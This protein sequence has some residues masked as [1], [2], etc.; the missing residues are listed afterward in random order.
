MPAEEEKRKLY[1]KAQAKA[2]KTQA[3]AANAA[4]A[5][6]AANGAA[7][8]GR[9]NSTLSATGS[10]NSGIINPY[11]YTSS[12]GLKGADLYKSATSVKAAAT[13]A[14][15][16]PSS[17][18]P[19]IKQTSPAAKSVS[20]PSPAT[21][22]TS[23]PPTSAIPSTT[24]S[25]PAITPPKQSNSNWLSAEDEKARLRYLD[26]KRAVDKHI[27]A[28]EA[29]YGA[30]TSGSSQYAAILPQSA[31]TPPPPTDSQSWSMAP[32][33][34][35]PSNLPPLITPT[36]TPPASDPPPFEP[37]FG[38]THATDIPEKEKMRLAL[39]H[40]DSVRASQSPPDYTTPPAG[41]LPNED[42]PNY[43]SIMSPDV[44]LSATEEKARLRAQFAAQDALQAASSSSAS[45][46]G[47]GSGSGPGSGSTGFPP[48]VYSRPSPDLPMA[49]DGS[50]QLTATED[51]ARKLA[52]QAAER[53]VSSI[54]PAPP[55]RIKSPPP[56]TPLSTI[57]E[58]GKSAI[59]DYSRPPAT[60]LLSSSSASSINGDHVRRDPSITQG[61]QRAP[62]GEVNQPF[63]PPPAPPPLMPRPP[64]EYIEK[65]KEEDIKIRRMTQ[66]A[67]GL[68]GYG[69][70]SGGESDSAPW[71]TNGFLNNPEPQF[72]LGLRPFS[73]LDLSLE[74]GV[75]GQ[76][77]PMSTNGQ[78]QPFYR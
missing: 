61:K 29:D 6:N 19:S 36:P 55:P 38:Y 13:T 16:T 10:I 52:L 45:G 23:T 8:V 75:T 18:P 69:E 58:H 70:K 12:S 72:S 26:A 64:A 7:G 22:P 53:P 40:Q 35:P 1:E 20:T 65:T 68:T 11:S 31:Y 14:A 44:I 62:S 27:A 34:P 49:A 43:G 32:L 60:P 33:S 74:T 4:S 46:S 48:S 30:S 59:P 50:R 76:P 28:Q 9:S 73:P 78:R 41:S 71:L 47:S 5:A 37:S 25:P 66:E 51:K 24:A 77:S 15:S 42:V 67:V 63:V 54:A 2:L 56:S 17:P 3:R 39:A 21:P 57:S